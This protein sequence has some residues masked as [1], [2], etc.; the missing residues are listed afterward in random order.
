[1]KMP[2]AM[3]ST[4]PRTLAPNAAT[5]SQTSVAGTSSYLARLNGLIR[6]AAAAIM[7][8]VANHRATQGRER[9]RGHYFFAWLT[10]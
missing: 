10:M 4:P 2:L 9:V 7:E 5:K 6:S 1:M 8:I 3:P